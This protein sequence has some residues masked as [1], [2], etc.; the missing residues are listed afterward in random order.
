MVF[1]A[2]EKAP[3]DGA[4]WYFTDGVEEPVGPFA[5]MQD[6]NTAMLQSFAHDDTGY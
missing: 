1:Y 4:G 6:A 2:T 5:S 3:L